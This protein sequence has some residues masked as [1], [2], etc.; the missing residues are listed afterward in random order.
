MQYTFTGLQLPL[1][2]EPPVSLSDAQ[3]LAFCK[4]HDELRV[5][6]DEHG[7]LLLM[8]PATGTTANAN[9]YLSR[10]FGN[11]TEEDGRGLA[12]DS[13]GG[14][15]LPDGSMRSPDVAWM[16]FDRW[17]RLTEDQQDSFVPAV[18]EFVIELRSKTDRLKPVQSKMKKWIVNGVELAWLLDPK[19]R[20][21]T[22]YRPD[23]E[24]E[25]LLNPAQVTGEGPVTG[26]VLPLARIFR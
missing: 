2:I 24:P 6:R 26:F 5:E 16:S 9:L 4:K 14:F 3:L 15:S 20:A 22:V 13:S 23:R 8:T 7:A 17:N 25:V 1:R 12:F 11:W 19:E 21:V 10:I 18:P